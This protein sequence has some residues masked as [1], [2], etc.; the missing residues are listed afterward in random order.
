MTSPA[1]QTRATTESSTNSTSHTVDLPSGI[2]SGDLLIAFFS[3][4]GTDGN[5]V[6]WPSGADLWTEIRLAQNDSGAGSSLAI[7]Y[8]DADG[9]EGSTIS[10][11]TANNTRF[12]ALV[13]R[14]TGH[15]DPATQAPEVST[16][17]TG[18]NSTA[19]PDSITPGS[20]KDYLFIAA[21][22]QSHGSDS[23]YTAEPTNYSNLATISNTTNQ[24][25]RRTVGTGERQLT[26]GSAE[27]PG[28]FTQAS[29]T[30]EW[31]AATVMVHPA[32]VGGGPAAGLRTLSTTGVGI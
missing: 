14:I 21:G 11:T 2:S 26:T 17:S 15:E 16:G 29:T 8:R 4:H 3:F 9:G 5:T 30:S 19:D 12:A 7:A 25:T 22:S 31:A 10:L 32:A 1:V 24:G 18:Q 13:L 6:T 20:S 23:T 27:D 28:T